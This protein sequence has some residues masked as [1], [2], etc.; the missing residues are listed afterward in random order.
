MAW[1]KRIGP[2]DLAGRSVDI[3]SH[4]GVSLKSF[5]N[6]EYPYGQ[7]LEGLS[8]ARRANG[9]D[10]GV[11]FPFTPELHFNLTEAARTGRLVDTDDP[12]SPVPYG[13]ENR[14][15]FT[16]LYDYCPELVPEMLPFL[17]IDPLRD[18]AGQL[19][20]IRELEERYPVYGIKVSPVLCQAPIK[21]LLGPGAPLLDYAASRGYPVI[22]HV[23]VHPEE[24]YSQVADT[25]EVAKSRP[26]VR[27]CFAHC[28]AFHHAHLSEADSLSNVWVDTSALTIQVEA[29]HRELEFMATPEERFPAD[30]SDHRKVMVDL[31]TAFPDTIVWGSD[32]PAYAYIAKRIQGDG[33]VYEFRLKARYE[34]E[35]AALD[36]LPSD[37]R[38]R[39]G[40]QNARNYLFGG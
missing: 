35:K 29:T 32:A 12:V 31:C 34:D 24:A 23:T 20:T 1:M 18:A 27:F 15:L 28:A 37:L 8:Y 7:S 4:A 26:D 39:I 10:L 11:V 25:L 36:A 19:E 17:C 21:A 22:A 33:S 40:T 13:V 6:N 5:A 2:E 9:I 16:E 30:Y 3:H 38:E 14:M